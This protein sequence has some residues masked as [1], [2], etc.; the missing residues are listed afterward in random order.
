VEVRQP[1]APHFYSGDCIR[2]VR[3]FLAG[4]TPPAFPEQ[5]LAGVVPHAGWQYSGAVAAK[6]YESIRRKSIPATLVIFGA[7][8]R[9]RDPKHA[10]YATGAWATPLGDVV[11]DEELAVAILEQTSEWAVENPQAHEEEHAIEVQLPFIRHLF[12]SARIVPISV[13]PTELAV[14]FGRRVGELLR[15]RRRDAV[16]IGS[17]DL[18]HYGEPYWFA[19]AGFGAPAHEWL[20]ANDA[21]ILRLAEQM[22]AE[23]LIPEAERHPNACGPGALAATVAAAQALGAERGYLLDYTTSYDVAPEPVF[24]MAV[25]YAGLLF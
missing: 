3:H 22:Q 24:R 11:V 20:R 17:T 9:R 16:V 4:F 10:V 12:P 23:E 21:R 18:T 5:I 7:V 15:E 2:A 19:P 8:H 1:A 25:G 6:V 14:P 13:N